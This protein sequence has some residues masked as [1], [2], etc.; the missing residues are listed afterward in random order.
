MGTAISTTFVSLHFYVSHASLSCSADI[1]ARLPQDRPEAGGYIGA[2][3]D[4]HKARVATAWGFE[5]LRRGDLTPLRSGVSSPL[6]VG[7]DR[8]L[9]LSSTPQMIRFLVGWS[10]RWG[11]DGE[12]QHLL[13]GAADDRNGAIVGDG[14]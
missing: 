11:R 10:V 5:R 13:A 12:A 9:A 1:S 3:D 6:S 7:F 4:L 8:P 2:E 14:H